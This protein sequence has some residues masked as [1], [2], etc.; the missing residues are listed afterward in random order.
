L[1]TFII[2]THNKTMWLL[3]LLI[4]IDLLILSQTG[5]RR[6]DVTVSASVSNGEQWTVYGTM[7]CGWTRKQLDYMKKNGKSFKFVDCD[8]EGCSGMEAFPTLVSP[9][10]E[11]I[12]GY[13]EI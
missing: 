4:L 11:Q 13:N 3:A 10:G 9:N 6:L 1:R 8:K 12:I 7:G 2:F 5:K